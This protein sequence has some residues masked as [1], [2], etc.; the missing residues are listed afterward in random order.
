[1][2]ELGLEIDK[3]LEEQSRRFA[4]WQHAAQQ[5]IQAK[6]EQDDQELQQ[7]LIAF[8]ARFLS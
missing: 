1:L 7:K 2:E 5:R 6:Q 8:L 3:Q 4:L